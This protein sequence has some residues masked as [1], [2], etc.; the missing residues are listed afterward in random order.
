MTQFYSKRDLKFQLFELIKADELNQIEYFQDHNRE[1]F[2]MILEAADQIAQKSLRPL[3]TEM[4]RNEP[5]LENGKIK[6]HP[7]MKS[8]IQQFGRDGWINATFSYEEGGQQLPWTIHIAAGFILQAAN[9]SASV[10]PFLT[11]G[12]ANLIRTF[13]SQE[14]IEK[15]TPNLYSGLWQGT[16]ALTEPDAGSSLSDLSTTAFPT[17]EAGVYKIKGQKI[18]I[19]CGDHDACENII[20]LMLARIDGAP[21]GTKGISLFVVP[22]KRIDTEE[23][24]DVLTQGIYHKMGYK[25]APIAHLMIGSEDQCEGYLVGEANQ[26]LKYM[27]Q[28]MNEARLGVGMNGVAIATAAYYSSLAYAKERPQGRRINNKDLNQPQ[29]PIIEHADVKRMLL[30]QKSVTEGSLALLL[31]C[32]KLA[33]EVQREPNS[34]KKKAKEALLDLLTPIAKSYPSEMGVHSTSA[35]VQVLGGAGYTTDFPVEQYYREARI[36]PIHEGT[37]GI[38]GLDL[39]GRKVLMSEGLAWK[40]LHQEILKSLNQSSLDPNLKS[41]FEKYHRI[42]LETAEKVLA[43][44]KK[45]LEYYLADA[46]LF[47][48]MC[49]ILCVAWKWLD[50]SHIAQSQLNGGSPEKAFYQGKIMASEY[51]MEYELTKIESLAARLQSENYPTLEMKND[52]F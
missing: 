14:L 10:F 42:V 17:D 36:H 19:S 15:F 13:G 5:Q 11:T 2:E 18:Y 20:H 40:L 4:D 7:G 30:F 38:H 46:T 3:L 52:W 21:A 25:G 37:T 47:L 49:G 50:Q 8:I 27:F 6:I 33:D 28:M 34:E 23:S 51:F 22:Q 35:A 43:R 31:Y 24:N 45:G 16:M 26:G 48:E 44:S 29:V 39:L 9:Y 32:S 1:T 41:R 12:A